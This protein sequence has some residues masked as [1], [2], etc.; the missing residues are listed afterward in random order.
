MKAFVS[1][2]SILVPMVMCLA[3]TVAVGCGSSGTPTP[4][5]APAPVVSVFD[6]G[7]AFEADEAKG[8]S[9]YASKT[10]KLV[11]LMVGD[12]WEDDKYLRCQPFHSDTKE[13]NCGSESFF[14]NEAI[15]QIAFPYGVNIR[16][17]DPKLIEGLKLQSATT[18]DGKVRTEYTDLVEVECEFD[19]LTDGDLFFKASKITKK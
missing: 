6:L 18:V 17:G 14:R 2:R 5:A 8:K 16:I 3:L 15:K 1:F 13:G 4:A 9:D 12:Y 10:I 11:D 19:S 7:K